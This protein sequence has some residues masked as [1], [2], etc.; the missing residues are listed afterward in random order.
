MSADATSCTKE[1]VKT[2]RFMSPSASPLPRWHCCVRRARYP[3]CSKLIT[4]SDWLRLRRDYDSPIQRTSRPLQE[5]AL[6]ELKSPGER[7]ADKRERP[8]SPQ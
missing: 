7:V 4:R 2:K 3:A 8:S 1:R 6:L 5:E